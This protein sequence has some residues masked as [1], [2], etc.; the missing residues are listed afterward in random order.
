VWNG[1]GGMGDRDE[2]RADASDGGLSQ[3]RHH[4]VSARRHAQNLRKRTRWT[5]NIGGFSSGNKDIKKGQPGG[6][7]KDKL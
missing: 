2:T 5:G 3:W 1:E 7:W 6:T 4:T